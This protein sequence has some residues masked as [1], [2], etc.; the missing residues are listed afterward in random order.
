M[1]MSPKAL[2]AP[3]Y[4]YKKGLELLLVGKGCSGT[5]L[6][7]HL[8]YIVLGEHLCYICTDHS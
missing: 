8:H 3:D 6:R 2:V 4:L 1:N 5:A 7:E